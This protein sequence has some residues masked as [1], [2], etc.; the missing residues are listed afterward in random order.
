M[1]KKRVMVPLYVKIASAAAA[2]GLLL[3]VG[4]WPEKQLPKMEP[5][6]ELKPINASQ[7][8]QSFHPSV[9]APRPS[10]F[11]KPQAVVKEKPV[12]IEKTETP[13]LAQLEPKEPQSIPTLETSDEPDF[14]FLAYRMNA[15]LDFAVRNENSNEDY[16]DDEPN[17]SLIGRGLL[18]LTNGRYDSFANLINS[19]IHK[20]KQ[21]LSEAAT[22]LALTAYQHV[23]EYFEQTRERREEKQRE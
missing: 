3:T 16:E 22:D 21:D 15:S 6:T 11:I 10:V 5:I 17:L 23:D 20:A 1:K 18:W 4:L 7:I 14:D 12:V 13:L 8:E 19:G 2:A 9:L